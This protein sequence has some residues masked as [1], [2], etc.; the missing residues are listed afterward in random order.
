MNR[1]ATKGEL[2]QHPFGVP[3]SLLSFA[4]TEKIQLSGRLLARDRLDGLPDN[5]GKDWKT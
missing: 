4:G 1:A 5:C 3:A 2:C